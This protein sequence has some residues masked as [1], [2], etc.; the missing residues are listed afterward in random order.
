[1]LDAALTPVSAAERQ[2]RA[3]N[4]RARGCFVVPM[5]MSEEFLDMLIAGGW[6]DTR[7]ADAVSDIPKVYTRRYAEACGAAAA[8]YFG[9]L[10]KSSRSRV[11]SKHLEPGYD[12]HHGDD[13]PTHRHTQERPRTAA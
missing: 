10:V 3:S 7:E 13:R 1:M 8:R 2:R 11:R 4:R 5:E 6:L 9:A 12:P